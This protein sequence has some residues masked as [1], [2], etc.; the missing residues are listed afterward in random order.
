MASLADAAPGRFAIGIGSSSNVIVE[1]WNGV[2]F[3]EPYKKVRDVVR[4]LRDALGGEKVAKRYDTFEVHG[5]RLGRPSRAAAA[6]PRRRAAR[7][8]AEARRP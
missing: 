7:G 3:V 4:F 2:P 8:H 6:D 1:R 5:F